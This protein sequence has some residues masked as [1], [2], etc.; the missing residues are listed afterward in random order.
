VHTLKSSSASLG[1]QSLA[2]SCAEIETLARAGA[3]G[4]IG[5]HMAELEATYHQAEQA[6]QELRVTFL[7]ESR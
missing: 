1:A 5:A 6:L 7:Q 3:I 4:E 2:A